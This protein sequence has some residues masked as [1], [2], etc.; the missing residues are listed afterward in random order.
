MDLGPMYVLFVFA[1]LHEDHYKD[2]SGATASP[3]GAL[4]PS[5][6]SQQI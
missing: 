3:G 4:T 2:K 5:P 1:G 6:E